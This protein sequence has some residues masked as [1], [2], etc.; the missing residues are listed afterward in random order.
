MS[1]F[2]S[3]IPE[4]PLNLAKAFNWLAADL[5]MVFIWLLQFNLPSMF[6]PKSLTAQRDR[7]F[8]FPIFILALAYEDLLLFNRMA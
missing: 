6:I 8:S 5:Q 7:I 4:K 2:L 3:S 1:A